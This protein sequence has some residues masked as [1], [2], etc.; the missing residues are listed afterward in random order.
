M[1]G[2]DII[3]LQEA[4]RTSNWQRARF[5]QKIFTPKEQNTITASANPFKT[6]WRFWSMKESAYKVIIQKGSKRFFNPTKLECNIIDSILGNVT[7]DKTT[8]NTSSLINSNFIFSTAADNQSNLNTQIFQLTADN[9]KHQSKFMQQQIINDFAKIN[10]LNCAELNIQKSHAG[11]PTLF[12]KNKQL[13]TSISIT[14][15]GKYGAYSF[16]KN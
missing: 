2:N 9:S 14:H 4:R 1:V 5:M 6:V 15:H 11:V 16:L 7:I 13:S 10:A 3:D 8:I 12:Y